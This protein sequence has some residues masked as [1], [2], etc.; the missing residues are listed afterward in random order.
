MEISQKTNGKKYPY[1]SVLG[2]KEL[3]K[4]EIYDIDDIVLISKTKKGIYVQYVNGSQPGWDT[5]NEEQ[6]TPL[7][8]GY[9]ITLK[10]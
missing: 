8:A 10:Q 5:Q 3:K 4:N 1:L 9:E 2:F 7:P 6:Y